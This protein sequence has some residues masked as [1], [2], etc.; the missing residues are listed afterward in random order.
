MAEKNARSAK[1]R[2]SSEIRFHRR[3]ESLRSRLPCSIPSLGFS[4]GSVAEL[5][6]FSAALT[7]TDT[8]SGSAHITLNSGST[9]DPVGSSGEVWWGASANVATTEVGT[10]N[11]VAPAAVPEAGSTLPLLG[12][13]LAGLAWC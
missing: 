12:L 6:Q 3:G 1:R 11:I 2:S 4:P 9:W 13:A 5:L 7:L 10:W 8:P